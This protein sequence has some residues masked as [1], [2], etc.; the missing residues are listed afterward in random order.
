MKEKL[1]LPVK[2]RKIGS[3]VIN[4]EYCLKHLKK[5]GEDYVIAYTLVEHIGQFY[6]PKDYHIILRKTAIQRENDAQNKFRYIS[7]EEL[8]Q[9][10]EE[11]QNKD[12]FKIQTN[13]NISPPK[14]REAY[15][16]E[17]GI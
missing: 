8:S 15:N 10:E 16:K 13:G 4:L 2:H 14:D 6:R 5:W 9:R 1:E 7:L 11:I 17:N 3:N 12:M